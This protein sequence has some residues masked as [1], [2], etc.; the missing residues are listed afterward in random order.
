[1]NQSIPSPLYL[2]QQLL[3]LDLGDGMVDECGLVVQ[4]QEAPQVLLVAHLLPLLALHEGV[5]LLHQLVVGDVLDAGLSPVCR[6]QQRLCVEPDDL[7][8]N[9][10][11]LTLT[12]RFFTSEEVGQL[13][14]A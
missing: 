1:M 13:T 3:P 8:A 12:N 2:L 6:V 5:D 4:L 11:D 10:C 9:Q 7:Q 14:S